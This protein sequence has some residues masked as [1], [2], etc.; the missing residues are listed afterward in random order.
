MQAIAQE[1]KTKG[2]AAVDVV[3]ERLGKAGGGYLQQFLL[4][5]TGGSVLGLTIKNIT[6]NSDV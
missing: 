1:M 4:I 5:I 6:T 3:G 2:K